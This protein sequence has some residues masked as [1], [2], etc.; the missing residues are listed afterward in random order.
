MK[1]FPTL[2]GVRNH[3]NRINWF[4]IEGLRE[5]KQELYEENSIDKRIHA[6]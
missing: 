1:L 6:P 5:E 3:Y 4:E 2:V